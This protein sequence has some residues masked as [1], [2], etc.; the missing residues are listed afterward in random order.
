MIRLHVTDRCYARL[1]Y[2]YFPSLKVTVDGGR[3]DPLVT[4]GRFVAVPLTSGDHVIELEATL[5]PLRRALWLL[6]ALLLI[7]WFVWGRSMFPR[8]H[9]R[10]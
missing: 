4:V 5:S 2:G 6:D 7:G 3:V 10:Q 9:P 1:A 8:A